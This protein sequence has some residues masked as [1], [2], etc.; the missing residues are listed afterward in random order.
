[1]DLTGPAI[2]PQDQ[3]LI[4]WNKFTNGILN[5]M[6]WSNVFCAGGAILANITRD[7]ENISYQN[8]D[9][10]LF[11]Y[12][13]DSEEAANQKLREIYEIVVKNS[14]SRGD[15][16]RSQNA[17]TILNAFPYRHTQVILRLY[18]SPAEI[19]LGFDVDACT[20]GFDGTNVYATERFK[21]AITKRYNLVDLSRRSATYEQRLDK[22]SRRGFAVAVPD[23]DKSKVNQYLQYIPTKYLYGL[24]KL[25]AYDFQ[26]QKKI[27][28]SRRSQRHVAESGGSDYNNGLNIPWAP[29]MTMS[30]IMHALE[31]QNKAYFYSQY[32]KLTKQSKKEG[33]DDK[34]QGESQSETQDKSQGESQEKPQNLFHTIFLDPTDIRFESQSKIPW[35][36]NNPIYQEVDETC[37]EQLMTAS[38]DLPNKVRSVWI[39]QC[40][41]AQETQ[42]TQETDIPTSLSNDQG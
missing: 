24:A 7:A 31:I 18:R 39:K 34:S 27:K 25:L 38:F 17:V 35:V 33:L 12:G 41:Y 19:L 4:R 36:R 9:I 2:V 11:I 10:D 8:S 32:K 40:Y 13:L 23:L 14:K 28:F 3:W 42:E 6:D 30:N 21:R 37:V 26:A 1:M 22:Y 16:I 29:F 5:G 15:V 20:V